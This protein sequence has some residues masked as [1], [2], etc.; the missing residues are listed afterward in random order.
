VNNAIDQT[1]N[2]VFPH[3]SVPLNVLADKLRNEVNVKGFRTD[4]PSVTNA[5]LFKDLLDIKQ[6]TP[7][8][9]VFSFSVF[10]DAAGLSLG[11]INKLYAIP[12]IFEVNDFLSKHP[13]LASLVLDA[14]HTIKEYFLESKLSLEVVC[15]AEFPG[16]SKLVVFIETNLDAEEALDK[17]NSLD[18]DWWIA[19]SMENPFGSKLSIE[20]KFT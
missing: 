17:L 10:G 6:K 1:I 4:F 15:D 3:D 8:V 9:K 13:D 19:A 16:W 12:N 11:R 14:H 2:L 7:T 20:L 18:D 5:S